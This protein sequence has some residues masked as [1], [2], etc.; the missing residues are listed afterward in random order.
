MSLDL[1]RYQRKY[2]KNS[3]RYYSTPIEW[4]RWKRHNQVLVK[5]WSNGTLK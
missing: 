3:V 4:L 5:V 2:M 1:I